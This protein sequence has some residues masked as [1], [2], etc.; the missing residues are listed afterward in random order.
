MSIYKNPN[1]GIKDMKQVLRSKPQP[2]PMEKQPKPAK[3]QVGPYLPLR[4][5]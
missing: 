2:K 3:P 4:G 5:Q 1:A